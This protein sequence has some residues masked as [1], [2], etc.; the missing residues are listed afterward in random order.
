MERHYN[1]W[2]KKVQVMDK[3]QDMQVTLDQEFRKSFKPNQN[4]EQK[5]A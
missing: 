4:D 1:H 2:I 3:S 5:L